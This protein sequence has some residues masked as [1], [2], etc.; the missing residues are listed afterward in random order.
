MSSASHYHFLFIG[1]Q[2]RELSVFVLEGG[3]DQAQWTP[4]HHY[5]LSPALG[6]LGHW[7]DFRKARWFSWFISDTKVRGAWSLLEHLC[8]ADT[9]VQ[10]WPLE[11]TL[12]L[13]MWTGRKVYTLAQEYSSH[14]T[15]WDGEH[16]VQLPSCTQSGWEDKW[17]LPSKVFPLITSTFPTARRCQTG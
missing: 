14:I 11:E 2:G 4:C 1:C 10:L 5:A 17:I 13:D 8:E 15:V 7:W 9:L 3:E 6:D 12:N 16:P